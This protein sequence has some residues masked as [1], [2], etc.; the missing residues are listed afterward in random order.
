MNHVTSI[1]LDVHARSITAVALDSITGEVRSQRFKYSPAEVASWISRFESP[2]AV[3]E[4]GVTGFHLVRA[5]RDLGIDCIV[6]AV[7]K[8]QRPASDKRKKNDRNDAEFLARQLMAHNIV[9]VFVPDEETDAARN[10]SRV[11]EDIRDD[12]TRAKHRLTHLLIKWGY[13]WDEYNEEGKRRGAWTRAHWEWIRKI[14]LPGSAAQESLDYY[15][16]EVRHIEAQ[17][18]AIE[19]RIAQ[20]V[21]RPRWNDRVEALRC[22]KGIETMT[23]FALVVET[24]VFSRFDSARSY[25]SWLGLVPSEHS[26]GEHVSRGGITKAGNSHLRKLL[27][28]ASW[29][30]T[31]ATK[32]RKRKLND[33]IVPFAVSSHAASGV[34][35]LVER[36]HH[37]AY[38]LRKRPVVANVA[39]AREL[40]CWIWALGRMSEG[41]LA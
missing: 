32:E 12:L 7:S 37:L 15:I 38:E 29:H 20:Y 17:K 24:G 22:M 26:S 13:V 11:L 8:M 6:G 34:K 2:K 25:A 4:S 19:K 39:T 14:E 10:L 1:G 3:Y 23:A 9:E 40:A 16:S 5:L 30:Y 35:R 33:P 31:R 27:V 18:K 36:R 21:Q 41:T 28:E